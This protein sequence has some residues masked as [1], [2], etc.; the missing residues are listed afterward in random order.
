MAA[1]TK[2][3]LQNRNSQ[4]RVSVVF[5]KNTNHCMENHFKKHWGAWFICVSYFLI[6]LQ[7]LWPGIHAGGDWGV[8]TDATIDDFFSL[9]N[10]ASW[11]SFS[12]WGNAVVEL[13]YF[14]FYFIRGFFGVFDNSY[15]LGM[16]VV[17]QLPIVII[18]PVG[19]YLLLKKFFASEM[20]VVLASFVYLLNTHFLTLQG[21]HITI[22]MAY[23][24]LPI[25]LWATIR[26]IEVG[27]SQNVAILSILL[28]FLILH[29]PRMVYITCLFFLPA[30]LFIHTRWRQ[31][32]TVII[33]IILLSLFWLLPL[34]KIGMTGI[35]ELTS[36]PVWGGEYQSL[37][38]ALTTMRNSW[39]GSEIKHF[40]REPVQLYFLI[41]PLLAFGFLVIRNRQRDIRK[42]LAYFASIIALLGILL[43]K[44]QGVPFVYLYEWLYV[45]MPGFSLFRES[46]KFYILINLSYA[47]LIGYTLFVISNESRKK[48][49]FFKLAVA[50]GML[51][52]V[53]MMTTLPVVTG[54][55]T[56]LFSVKS[57]SSEY[58]TFNEIIE[59]DSE[60]FRTLIIPSSDRWTTATLN[61]PRISLSDLHSLFVENEQ[62]YVE[63]DYYQQVFSVLDK[64]FLDD[65][66]DLL[67][68]KYV[69]LLP[70]NVK[71]KENIFEHY[72]YDKDSKIREKY[73]QKLNSLPF[74]QK[75]SSDDTSL[76]IYR[77]KDYMPR[78]FTSDTIFKYETVQN[79][80]QKNHFSKTK[81]D[82]AS[83]FTLTGEVP[84]SIAIYDLFEDLSTWELSPGDISA[85]A[86][87]TSDVLATLYA[88]SSIEIRNDGKYSYKG[89]KY[90]YE[91]IIKNGSFAD[92]LWSAEVGNCYNYDENPILEMK[93]IDR[94]DG[95]NS[96][97]LELSATRHI[98]CTTQQLPIDGSSTYLLSFDH[99][100]PTISKARYYLGYDNGLSEVSWVDSNKEWQTYKK[101]IETPADIKSLSLFIYSHPLTEDEKS[102]NRY[103]NVTLIKIPELRGIYYGIEEP[104]ARLREPKEI[105]FN[106]INPTKK[107]VHIKGATT[108]FYLAMSESFHPQ[109]Q[110]QFNNEKV[111]GF[112]D[113]WMPFVKPDRIIDEHHFE[114][115]GFLN[116][117]YI[118]TAKYCL[119]ND[120]CTQNLDGSY[121]IELVL[122]FFPQR[123]FYLGL[124]IS[125]TTFISILGYLGYSFIRSRRKDID[126]TIGQKEI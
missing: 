43:A 122:E 1:D 93:T 63:Q 30:L 33:L 34:A 16:L 14:P 125:S 66:L 2:H 83:L 75:E 47:Y 23:V 15:Y 56:P 110:A 69:V 53:F 54:V 90:Q 36:R 126:L 55:L 113:S 84:E 73:I 39:T 118:D 108:P 89:T 111:N 67:S 42:Y 123:W 65:Y 17:Y 95:I 21:E 52:I 46:S 117:W 48:Q 87:T 12:G 80:A 51:I 91:N 105:S 32:A 3:A 68:V 58:R 101:I 4:R 92:G 61:H 49:S 96:N 27:T 40:S 121:D 107:L 124:L 5:L 41:L 60:D 71:N 9:A 104:K 100:S 112:F 76:V 7:W 18:T 78:I 24:F 94:A 20:I 13:Y 26:L 8:L 57:E 97:A 50:G 106:L 37:L 29:E 77:N 62:I 115:N 6:H 103:D 31:Y 64:K 86:E 35:T 116:G 88:S 119:E 79:L 99:Q 59:N 11:Q 19:I 25:T 102:L 82:S 74:L 85:V 98:A 81:Y 114:L 120:L 70:I 38:H 109:W 72:G 45:N 44:Q 22:A 10:N 28:F